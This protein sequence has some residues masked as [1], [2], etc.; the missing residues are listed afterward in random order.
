MARIKWTAAAMAAGMLA[1]QPCAAAEDYRDAGTR[2]RHASAFGGVS[3]RV[4]LGGGR[5]EK[6]SARLQLTAASTIRDVRSGATSTTRAHGLEIGAGGAGKPALY[7]GGRNTA[8]MKEKLGIGGKTTTIVVVA[9]VVVLLL[10][11]LAASQVPP[12][13]DF[14]D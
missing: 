5:A 6:P 9:G 8:E 11:I 4:P 14:D 3:M 7:M 1:V 13:P 12:Q 2:E 10:V